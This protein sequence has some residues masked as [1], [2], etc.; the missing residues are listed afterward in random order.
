MD[1]QPQVADSV[2]YIK[3]DRNTSVKNKKKPKERSSNPG[4]SLTP[5]LDNHRVKVKCQMQFHKCRKL[6]DFSF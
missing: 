5:Q 4:S 1:P 3:S 2:V 6:S